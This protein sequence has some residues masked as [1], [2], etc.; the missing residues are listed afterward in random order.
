MSCKATLLPVLSGWSERSCDRMFQ[1]VVRRTPV[2]KYL[3]KMKGHPFIPRFPFLSV[4]PLCYRWVTTLQCSSVCREA[5]AERCQLS[6]P[7]P[8][9]TPGSLQQR[10]E[11]VRS[12]GRRSACCSPAGT[13]GCAV[14]TSGVDC[15]AS[16]RDCQNWPSCFS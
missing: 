12:A 4:P 8:T 13:R 1:E 5:A 14:K 3:L 2:E 10:G 7:P 9:G 6:S 11:C 15:A 16:I